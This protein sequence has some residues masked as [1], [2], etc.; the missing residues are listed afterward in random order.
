MQP[1][2]GHRPAPTV[3]AKAVAALVLGVLGLVGAPCWL[4]VPAGIPA[5][6]LGVLALQTIR[7]SDGLVGGKGFAVAGIAVGSLAAAVFVVDGAYVAFMAT[8]PTIVASAPSASAS[9][10]PSASSATVE[11][12]PFAGDGSDEGPGVRLHPA[13][14][15]PL[16]DQLAAEARI[17]K[18]TGTTVLVETVAPACSACFEIARAMRDPSM[19]HLVGRN[20]LV[21][22]DL[23]EFGPEAEVLDMAER[24][25]PWFYLVDVNGHPRDGISADEWEDNVPANIEP[26]LED[27]V[28]GKLTG[29]KV[30][31]RGGTAL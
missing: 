21:L 20:R 13:T 7:K 15:R 27:F 4:G 1:G 17:A 19:H 31:W 11:P 26:V 8:R 16:R 29:R 3:D 22:V 12:A 14:A 24:S 28:S 23:H 25:L 9:A 30:P 5:V 10:P 2:W 18:L 6:I